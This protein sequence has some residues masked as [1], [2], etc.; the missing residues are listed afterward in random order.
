MIEAGILMWLV[1]SVLVAVI[2]N[3]RG[4]SA[5]GYFAMSILLSPI[6]TCIFVMCMPKLDREA[7]RRR[8]IDE[9]NELDR[10]PRE[11]ADPDTQRSND[12]K[13]SVLL[14]IS[15]AALVFVLTR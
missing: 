7:E 5:L 2:A 15:V 12:R 8:R 6:I 9:Q 14:L 4:R 11:P 10:K 1:T 13:W 3:A